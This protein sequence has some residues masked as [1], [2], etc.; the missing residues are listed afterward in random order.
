MRSGFTK[1]LKEGNNDLGL[2]GGQK[3]YKMSENPLNICV[4]LLEYPYKEYNIQ[5]ESA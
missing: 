2:G 5:K 4:N 3:V 1:R